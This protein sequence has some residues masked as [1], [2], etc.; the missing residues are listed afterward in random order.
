MNAAEP[1]RS[2]SVATVPDSAHPG[3][4][5]AV[6]RAVRTRPLALVSL[7]AGVVAAAAV[8]LYGLAADVLGVPMRAGGMGASESDPIR[9]G[10]FAMGTAMNVVLGT[11]LA[12]L[13][14]RFAKA[15]ARTYLRSA[16]ALTVL[17]FVPPLLAGDTPVSTKLML[18][19]SHVVVAAIVIPA[20]TARLS[21]VVPRR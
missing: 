3:I 10:M 14:A 6:E 1:V 9:T 5:A 20:V 18:C 17:S 12:L 13:V 8:E 15:P 11:V 7:G 21:G 4:R 19:V 2:A 16:V